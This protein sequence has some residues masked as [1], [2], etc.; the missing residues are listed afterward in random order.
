MP[1]RGIGWTI[2]T[3]AFAVCCIGVPWV[4]A[5]VATTSWLFHPAALLFAALA[6]AAPIAAKRTRRRR[7]N[8]RAGTGSGS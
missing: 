7:R 3:V 2:G 4:I 6:G 1:E 5:A 8:G